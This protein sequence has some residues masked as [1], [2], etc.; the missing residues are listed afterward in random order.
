MY[1]RRAVYDEGEVLDLVM[2]RHRDTRSALRLLQ[3]LIMGQPTFPESICTDQQRSTTPSTLSLI[4]SAGPPSVASAARLLVSGRR[5]QL[6]PR[7]GGA[8]GFLA[9]GS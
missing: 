6:L 5:P 7:S 4:S 1:L 3:A 2:Q 8:G 9:F